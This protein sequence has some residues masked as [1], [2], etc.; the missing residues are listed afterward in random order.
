MKRRTCIA[1]RKQE[2]SKVSVDLNI[3][4]MKISGLSDYD[5]VH[6][7]KITVFNDVDVKLGSSSG[8]RV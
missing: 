5:R 6:C 4:G 8:L 1:L 3:S 7:C 2:Y